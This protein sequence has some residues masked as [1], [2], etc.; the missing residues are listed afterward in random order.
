VVMHSIA[1]IGAGLVGIGLLSGAPA[2]LAQE[3]QPVEQGPKNVP[4]FE[5]AFEEQ[6]RAPAMDSGVTLAVE[7]IA[8]GLAHP[9][10][11]AVTPPGDYLVTE[12]PGRLRVVHAD[13]RVSA[14]VAGLPEVLAEEQGGLL[15]VAVD[16]DFG[17]NRLIYWTY[18]KPMADGTSATAAA[19]GRLAEDYSEVTEVEDIFVQEPPSPSPMHYGSRLVFD[20]EGNVFITT[21]E[22]FT[23]AERVNAQDLGTTYGKVIRVARDGAVPADNPFAG[24]DGAIGTIWSYGHRNIQA[25]AIRPGT[26]NLWIVEHGPQGGDELN[27]IEPGAN[28]GWPEVSYGENYDGTPVGSGEARHAPD[29]EEPRYY[30]DPVIAPSGMAFYQGEM[31]PGWQG[32]VLI[33]SLTP[34]AIVRLELSGQTVLGEER[35]LT[36]RGRIRDLEVAPDGALLALVD[37]EDGALLRLTP[38]TN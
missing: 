14:P 25:A 21:G 31:F 33:G 15:D 18:S 37:A 38:A 23:P 5:P 2:A 11:I 13:G 8:G 32:D 9:W 3:E 35:L 12:R 36:D 26:G 17:E 1:R 7:E 19:R 20:G 29:F 30:W 22:H 27:R 24:R 6:T 4:E 10:G 16:P 28:Y 34:G